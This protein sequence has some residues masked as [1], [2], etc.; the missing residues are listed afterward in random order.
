MEDGW[1]ARGRRDGEGAVQE[2]KARR[3]RSGDGVC[4]GHRGTKTTGCGDHTEAFVLAGAFPVSAVRVQEGRAP[5][6][7]GPP[8]LRGTVYIY[9]KEEIITS[10]TRR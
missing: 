8:L 4:A 9:P 3:W 2:G 1:V 7:I 10:R 5:N 6:G